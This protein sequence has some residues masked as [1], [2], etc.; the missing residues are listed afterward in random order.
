MN[1]PTSPAR[2]LQ[3]AL[4]SSPAGAAL[5]ERHAASQRAAAAIEPECLRIVPD[6]APTRSGVC[7]LR[8]S[9]LRVNARS[10]AQIAKLRQAGPRLL[11]RLR[12]QGLD[13][14]EIKFGVQPRPLSSSVWPQGSDAPTESSQNPPSFPRHP[15]EIEHAMGF[16]KQLVLTLH[17]SPL[18]EA[19]RN[20]LASLTCGV[21]RMRDSGQA[22]RNQSSKKDQP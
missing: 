21:A 13:V 1:A 22:N 9:T 17:D 14:I 20:L 16:A 12:Q 10:P 3:D 15:S 11:S 8:G 6:L 5:L 4:A 18:R 7:E 19:A 2:R